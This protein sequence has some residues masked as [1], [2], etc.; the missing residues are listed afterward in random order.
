VRKPLRIRDM[1]EAIR[2]IND[3]TRIRECFDRL[4]IQYE[5]DLFLAECEL[6]RIEIRLT[7]GSTYMYFGEGKYMGMGEKKAGKEF[8]PVNNLAKMMKREFG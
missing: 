3:L 6:G 1:P 7:V 4:N 5:D 8:E 2:P